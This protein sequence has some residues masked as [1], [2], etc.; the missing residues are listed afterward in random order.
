VKAFQ[1]G[2]VILREPSDPVHC[3]AAV[4]SPALGLHMP[5]GWSRGYLGSG[6]PNS[7]LWLC[8][9]LCGLGV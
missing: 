9:E 2:S 8:Y 3:N 5:H 4:E 1:M 7:A 6:W